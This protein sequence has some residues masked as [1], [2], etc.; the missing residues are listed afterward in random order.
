[1]TSISSFPEEQKAHD[2][3]WR[4]T[5]KIRMKHFWIVQLSNHLFICCVCIQ[6]LTQHNNHF[7]YCYSSFI[8]KSWLVNPYRSVILISTPL[9]YIYVYEREGKETSRLAYS[10][11][12]YLSNSTWSILPKHLQRPVC[13]PGSMLCSTFSVL[14]MADRKIPASFYIS[15][16]LNNNSLPTILRVFSFYLAK[17]SNESSK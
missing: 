17:N 13:Q 3:I 7:P 11:E 5:A 14:L 6:V 8:I 12:P 9:D 10:F 15:K 1:M 4:M 2:N 16:C